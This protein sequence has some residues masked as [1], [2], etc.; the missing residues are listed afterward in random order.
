MISEGNEVSLKLARNMGY[1]PMR[2][3]E[4]RPG[5]R[6]ELMARD[7]WHGAGGNQSQRD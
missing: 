2:K 7:V 5:D 4:T 6:V 1:K 3:A